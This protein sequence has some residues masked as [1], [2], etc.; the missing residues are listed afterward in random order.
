MAIYNNA[1][2]FPGSRHDRWKDI[3][4]RDSGRMPRDHGKYPTL[5]FLYKKKVQSLYCNNFLSQIS[6]FE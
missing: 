2:A 4:Y 1:I 5:L 6:H 3:G